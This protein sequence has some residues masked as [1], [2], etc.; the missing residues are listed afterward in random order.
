[1]DSN[2]EITGG[3]TRDE[4]ALRRSGRIRV[5]KRAKTAEA[6]VDAAKEK[7]GSSAPNTNI[8]TLPSLHCA[9]E[10][11]SAKHAAAIG[12]QQSVSTPSDVSKNTVVT[13]KDKLVLAI[14]SRRKK[15]KA[16]KK[17]SEAAIAPVFTNPA[18]ASATSGYTTNNDNSKVTAASSMGDSGDD[19]KPTSKAKSGGKT[20][21]KRQ[22]NDH[23]GN[24][25][26]F[27]NMPKEHPCFGGDHSID[28]VA[29]HS[30]VD[31]AN[32]TYSIKIPS[33]P[34]SVVKHYP[35]KL[36]YEGSIVKE[37]KLLFLA[38]AHLLFLNVLSPHQ[39]TF[40]PFTPPNSCLLVLYIRSG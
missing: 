12:V 8:T 19:T 9:K 30:I 26:I 7:F 39:I 11:D 23:D 5:Q 6:E 25:N 36:W 10:K 27:D 38:L 37:G 33:I 24:Y 13:H 15:K 35:F 2:D 16:K 17:S 20:M 28:M 18:V 3:G 32:F 29:Y 31:V 34:R 4:G 21:E 22:K 1:M 40:I 14:D